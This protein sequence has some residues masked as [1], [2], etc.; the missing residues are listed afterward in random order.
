MSE[1]SPVVQ[2]YT[3]GSCDPNPGPG[4]WAAIVRVDEREWV[5]HGSDPATTNNRMELQAAIAALALLDRLLGGC[6]VELHTDSQYLRRGVTEWIGKWLRNGW[7]TQDE[8]PVKNQDLWQTLHQLSRVHQVTWRWLEGHAGHPLN[9]RADRLARQARRSLGSRR[10]EADPRDQ[11]P[12]GAGLAPVDI[13]IKAGGGGGRP[14]VWAAVLRTGDHVRD[15]CGSDTSATTNALL[16][17]AA[18]EA[19]RALTRPCRVTVYSDAEYLVKGAS[20]WIKGWQARGW[21][22]KDGKPVAN[23][24]E[25]ESLLE[26][27]ARHAVTWRVVDEESAPPDMERAALV[28]S[29]AFESQALEDADVAGFAA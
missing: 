22:T 27:A 4:G 24:A 20:Q 23:R 7:Q 19:L 14:G 11:S 15:L 12:A 28:A 2:V 21:Q 9:E 18:A 6:Q 25:W 29:E 13:S 1:Q 5:L 8:E 3:D 26:A 10:V 17:R 16:I